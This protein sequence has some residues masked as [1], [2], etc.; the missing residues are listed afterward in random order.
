MQPGSFVKYQSAAREWHVF[1][2]VEG[3][4]YGRN[5]EAGLSVVVRRVSTGQ[6][7]T[8]PPDRLRSCPPSFAAQDGKRIPRGESWRDN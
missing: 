2:V 6:V 7:F 1:V 8:M 3:A 5:K 4:L